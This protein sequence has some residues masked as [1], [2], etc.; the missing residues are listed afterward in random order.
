MM[1]KALS[2]TEGLLIV[3]DESA[4]SKRAVDYVA[5]M[6]GRRR[7]FH[8]HLLHLLPPL[9]PEL[10]EFGGSE[11]PLKEE[12]LQAELHRD[13]QTWIASRRDSAKPA[14]DEAIRSLHEAGLAR[15]QIDCECPGPMDDRDISSAVLSQ[16]R[17][18]RCRT[19]VIGHE[20]HSW[21]HELAGGN[22]CEHLFRIS[23]VFTL[24][25]VQ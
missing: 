6:I 25:V 12:L 10:M 11:D 23:S 2:H 21:F 8:V 20:S 4:G 7:G 18:K 19:I 13:Q 16:A 3:V 17:A 1:E 5:R 9:P 22:L 24:W 15:R 14:L